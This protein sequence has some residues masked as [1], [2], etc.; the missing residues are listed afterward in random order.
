MTDVNILYASISN[1]NA[2]N[3]DFI[4]YVVKLYHLDSKIKIR[5][6]FVRNKTFVLF[7]KVLL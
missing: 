3:F 4:S 2:S 1:L 5:G 7:A 6:I